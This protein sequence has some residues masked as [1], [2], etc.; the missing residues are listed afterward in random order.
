[1]SEAQWVI[2]RSGASSIA[3]LTV[4]GRPS[5][6][7]PFAAAAGDHQV[8]NAQGLIEAG[9]AILIREDAA[10]PE[11]LTEHILMVLR[12]GKAAGQMANN[13]LALGKPEAAEALADMIF[14]LTTKEPAA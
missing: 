3:D 8:A 9:A 11:S 14:E 5:I 10:T 6:L 1:M 7:I 13:A 4:I 12:D 2:S